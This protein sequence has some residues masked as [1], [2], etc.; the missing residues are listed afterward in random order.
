MNQFV[1]Y[2]KTL[3]MRGKTCRILTVSTLYADTANR[4][5]IADALSV[6]LDKTSPDLVFFN[7]D[8]TRG[9]GTKDELRRTLDVILAPV[10]GRNLPWA[11]V[12]GDMDRVNGLPNEEAMEVYRSFPD[13]MSEAGPEAVDGCGNYILTVSGEDGEPV[14]CL[15][16]LDSHS[17][18]QGY[19][20][21]YGS[22]TR[23][24]LSNPLYGKY[25]LDGIRFNQSMFCWRTSAAMEREY[26]R[27]IPAMFLFHM[28][29][30]EMTYIPM[31]Q[32]QTKMEGYQWETVR[33]Q[34][35]AGGLFTAALE[36]GDVRAM[37]AGHSE[38]N[39]FYGIY[40][41]ILMGQMRDF[42]LPD[43]SFTGGTL[44]EID[45]DGNVGVSHAA[46]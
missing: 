35:V 25:Y 21:D 12:F 6:L 17:A 45:A 13:C 22:P 34:V 43:G 29:V 14:L 39:D 28:P 19:E 16:G 20:T 42:T 10:V 41:R 38:R 31:N 33:C 5:R 23:A 2:N 24:R 36:R 40:G 15:Y 37:F 18:V 27:K 3:R 26:G 44:F 1:P 32:T 9:A 8:I 30:P 4:D 11:H 46:I 7:G